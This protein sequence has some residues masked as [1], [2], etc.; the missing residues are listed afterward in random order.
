MNNLDLPPFPIP[1]ARGPQVCEAV[2]FYLALVDE[3]PFEQVRVL[4]EHVKDCPACAAE[5][6][7]LQQSARLLA[8]LPESTPSA[9]VD[10]AIQV[11]LRNQQRPV[12]HPA[13]PAL[14][15]EPLARQLHAP[16]KRR[17]TASTRRRMGLLS[18]AAAVLL[19]LVVAG[20]FL[21]GI[22]WPASPATAFQL[23]ANLSW[24]GYVLHYTQTQH[25]ARGK[26]YQVEVY[27]D[28][29][30]N[31]MHIESR[32]KGAF[33]VVVVTD[34]Q[35][36]LGKD[37]MHHIAQ[38]GQ[39][40]AQ[41]A[42]DGSLFDLQQLRQDLSTQRASYLGTSTFANQEVYQIRASN[43]EILL[44]NMHYLP[45]NVLAASTRASTPLYSVCEL[46]PTAQV[47]D[48]MWDMRVPSNFH[49]GKLPTR[50]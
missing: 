4:S 9:R 22:I 19:I 18:L 29:A 50:A 36:M 23:P 6:Q 48:S 27:Q 40:V 17:K 49:M 46:M 45:V 16:V 2:R 37:M 1:G 12:R 15:M 11:F 25:D 34:Q 5:F 39:S 10:Q 26:A 35:D 20:V 21:R 32:M 24:S 8:S 38:K 3:L 30:T 44:L 42:V 7:R 14:S 43:N 31:Q 41:W 47:D 28:L 13:Q 33:D